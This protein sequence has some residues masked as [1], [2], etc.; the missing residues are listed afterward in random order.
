L[1]PP[2]DFLPPR[3]DVRLVIATHWDDDHIRGLGDVVAACGGARVACSAALGRKDILAFVIEQEAAKGALGSGLD[4]FRTILRTCALRSNPILWAKANLP[5][6]PLPPGDAPTVVA[7]SPSEDAFQ[8]SMES[9]IEAAT[10]LRTTLPPRRYKA[11][12]GPNGASIATSI[13][14]G[15]ISLLLGADLEVSNNKE[16]G[17]DAVLKYSKPTTRASAVKVP[18]HGS[19]GAHH[20]RMWTELAEGDPITVL[21]PW[22]GG[23]KFLPNEKDLQRLCEFS[24]RVF[25]TAVPSL[26]RAKKDPELDRMI[27]RLHGERI[28]ELRGWGHVR[29]LRRLNADQW[30]VDMYGDAV[31]VTS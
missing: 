17:W 8:R 7:L 6:H 22:M 16:T 4:E 23:A 11:P 2:P 1:P 10:G 14:N 15:N 19:I 18:H 30:H 26:V 3:F 28:S 21:T 13:R 5:L 12:E 25:L 20:E 9:L 29:A 24:S 31:A 27:R